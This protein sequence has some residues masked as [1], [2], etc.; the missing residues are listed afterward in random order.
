MEISAS[1]VLELLGVLSLIA[2]L[3]VLVLIYSILRDNQNY[4]R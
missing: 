4:N 2:I 3:I 1:L